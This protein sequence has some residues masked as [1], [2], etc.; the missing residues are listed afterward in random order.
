MPE[1]II[2]ENLAT[3]P[4]TGWIFVG[5]PKADLPQEPAGWLRD[6]VQRLPWVRELGGVRVLASLPASTN[7]PTRRKL[8]W[9]ASAKPEPFAFHPAITRDVLGILP[10]YELDG[11]DGHQAADALQLV[12]A[13]E[14]AQVWRHRVTWPARRVTLD[15]YY[16]VTSQHP[17]IEFG[18]HAVYGTTA[19][20]G[21]PQVVNDLGELRMLSR[22]QIHTDFARRNGHA[23]PAWQQTTCVQQ[24]VPPGVIWHRASRFELRGALLTQYDP[25]RQEGRPMQGVYTGWH[26]DWL[27]LGKIP[28]RT[29]DLDA[30]RRQQLAAYLAPAAGRY[31][32]PRPRA[33]PR[34]S[35]T[36]G[37]QPDFGASS[38]LAVV[39]LDPWEIHD[40]LWQCQSFAQ[41]PTG[42][43]EPNGEPMRAELHPA[44]RTHNQRPDL[45][46]GRAD[47]LGWPGVN[48]ILWIPSPAT[49]EWT[50]GDDQHR[51]DLLLHATYALT[52]DPLLGAII[53]DHIEL[54]RTDHYVVEHLVPAPRAV[55]R[56]ALAR[57]NQVW[58]GFAG[59]LPT[60]TGA[61]DDAIAST[62]LTTLPADRIVRTVGGREQA[63]YGWTNSQTGQPVIGWQP[64]QEAIA[65]I[66]M[67]AAANVT[68]GHWSERAGNY[69][70]LVARTV[71]QQG[72]RLEAGRWWHAYA[73]AWNEG[74]AWTARTDWPANLNSNGD[75][76]TD[77]I[78][79][80]GACTPWTLAASQIRRAFDELARAQLDA[81]GPPRTIAEARWRAI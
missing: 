43:R 22:A 73:V 12:Q 55:G 13:S 45:G 20:D 74:R 23:A 5:M 62:P 51:S 15:A 24:I 37:D 77:A 63:K 54:D 7:V 11:I 19:N 78:F 2:V 36:T 35:G 46:L 79:V 68:E 34:S 18:L 50:T 60:L 44:A 72:W 61:I 6:G 28:Q 27:A 31:V 26:N 25:A 16:T 67:R 10:R 81:F 66:G 4:Q 71:V 14:A 52:R 30:L 80:T 29:P 56:L 47:R 65:A 3:L 33:Q 32:D 58:L 75:G 69:A 64:W 59:A 48:A 21:Q 38:D 9:D 76:W 70:Y 41:R 53:R 1:P 49:C 17:T 57:A 42:N 8:E 40:A 39:T